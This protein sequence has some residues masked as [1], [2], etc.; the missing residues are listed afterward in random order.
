LEFT[1]GEPVL[2]F[3]NPHDGKKPVGVKFWVTRSA[4][5]VTVKLYTPSYRKIK[6]LTVPAVINTGENTLYLNPSF[7][8]TLSNGVYFFVLTVED[9]AGRRDISTIREFLIIK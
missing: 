9:E 3:P 7:A 2:F 5:K 8:S 4:S 1:K 6:E